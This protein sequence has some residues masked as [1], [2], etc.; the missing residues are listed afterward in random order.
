MMLTADNHE[1]KNSQVTR[2][3]L[4]TKTYGQ[5][6]DGREITLF[7]IENSKGLRAQVSNFGA[8]L[9]AMLVPDR[10]GTIRDLV[11][12]FDRCEDWLKNEPYFGATVG[13]FG[14]RIAAGKF[15]LEGKDYVLATNN[16]P[17]GVPCHLHGGETGFSHVL[18]E[19]E[20][21][22]NGVQFSY[23]SQD[24]DEGYPGE[25]QLTVSYLL[26]DDDELIWKTE[27]TTNRST[28]INIIHHSYWNLSG[29]PTSTI[30]NH[31]L[32]INSDRYLSTGADMIP[33]G[34]LH[35]V[36]NTPMDFKN[37][38]AIGERIEDDFIAL[39]YGN[40]YDHCWVLNGAG[41]KLAAKATDPTTGRSLEVFTDQ[42][43]VHFYTANYLDQSLKGKKGVQYAQRS[44]F[45]LETE[46]YPDA[47]NKPEFPNCILHPGEIYH[48]TI[49]HKFSW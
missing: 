12:G 49:V 7:T 9:V 1:K 4:K 28:P 25:L 31:L 26:N 15:S 3:Q 45:C 17:S 46:N 27:A 24:G 10:E 2:P 40:G 47:P 8:T 5:M 41:M 36:A 18:W 16:E 20:L 44:A 33:T 13:R 34:E 21:L 6:P 22:T 37:A 39:Q 35:P 23:L 38:T 29:D 48:H 32:H 11:H 19:A 30:D 43:A 14:N 42:P